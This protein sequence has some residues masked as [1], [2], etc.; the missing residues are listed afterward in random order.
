MTTY[1]EKLADPVFVAKLESKLTGHIV[2]QY[3]KAGK[4][5]PLPKLRNN[6]FHFDDPKVQAGADRIRTGFQLMALVL[7]EL[8]NKEG[9]NNG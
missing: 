9:G 7:D 6:I 8:E 4:E 1:L 2:E 5:L 3:L